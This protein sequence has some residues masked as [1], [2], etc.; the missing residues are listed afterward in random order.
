MVDEKT[1]LDQLT[2]VW[3]LSGQMG[4]V[5]LR[6]RVDAE[7]TLGGHFVKMYFTSTTGEGNPTSDYEAVYHIGFNPSESTFVM[8]LLDTTEIPLECAMGRGQREGNEIAFTF[9]YG[10]TDFINRFIWHPDR[11]S[12]RFEQ[13]F[14]EMGE[15]RVF[16]LKEMHRLSG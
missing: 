10:E 15:K 4:D 8:H 1:F 3:E 14:D 2:G 7:W 5:P 6:Q 13:T 12:W 16:A 11:D 9:R